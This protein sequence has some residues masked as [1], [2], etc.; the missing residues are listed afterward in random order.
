MTLK[1]ARRTRFRQ[2]V[3]VVS[4]EFLLAR[5]ISRNLARMDHVLSTRIKDREN[6]IVKE[7]VTF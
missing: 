5:G 2:K 6:E 7:N 3:T 4:S 1:P